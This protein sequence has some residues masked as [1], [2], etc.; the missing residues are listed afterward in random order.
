MTRQRWTPA[1]LSLAEQAI[2][3]GKP[4]NIVASGSSYRT[5]KDEQQE[6][7]WFL[8]WCSHQDVT[9]E[10]DDGRRLTITLDIP[11]IAYPAGALLSGD[12]RNR[13]MQWSILKSM[14]CKKDVSDLVL[15]WPANGYHGMHIEMKKRRDQFKSCSDASRAVSVGQTAYLELMHRLGY[16]TCV[17]FGWVEAARKTCTYLGWD[18]SDRG[19]LSKA[20]ICDAKN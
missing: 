5:K 3:A 9:Y 13:A 4:A 12:K 11:M 15:N 1:D 17:A 8:E 7:I 14:G 19:L 20:E 18:P 16:F 6:Q 2:A 10:D